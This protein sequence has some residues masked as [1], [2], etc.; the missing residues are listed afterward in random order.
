M[1]NVIIHYD[2]SLFCRRVASS[3]EE[4][5]EL[6][7]Q[8]FDCPEWVKLDEGT[9][10]LD[11]LDA[12]IQQRITPE[13]RETAHELL[14]NWHINLPV[15]SEMEELMAS[16]KS[17]GY[18]LYLL[19]NAGLQ[20]HEYEKHISAFQYLDGK[21]I[22]ADIQCIK[23]NPA[24]YQYLLDQYQLLP[25]QCLFIDDAPA[26]IDG[27]KALGIQGYCYQDGNL[28]RLRQYLTELMIL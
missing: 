12:L 25:S 16:L 11:D 5:E 24:I 3:P 28:S 22:S 8:I 1:G 21:V 18:H 15:Y 14:Y 4:A 6:K 7:R 23:P 10:E 9:I 20:F 27:A 19:S 13:L 26:N 2:P 17:R